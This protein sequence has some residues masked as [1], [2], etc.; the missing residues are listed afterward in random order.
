MNVKRMN[1]TPRNTCKRRAAIA[2]LF[3]LLAT[4]LET[5]AL[6]LSP[7]EVD[8]G[9]VPA[10]STYTVR[11]GLYRSPNEMDGAA[12]ITVQPRKSAAGFF[13]GETSFTIPAGQTDFNYLFSV[14]PTFASEA[15]Q[16]LYVTFL[17]TPTSISTSGV[18]VIT[19]VTQVIRFT[20][21]TAMVPGAPT[22]PSVSNGD[23]RVIVSFTAPSDNG[24]TAVTSYLVTC[25]SSLG[26][27]VSASAS[28]SPVTVTGL[29]NG[30]VYSCFVQARNVIGA[31]A[32]STTVDA[33]PYGASGGGGGASQGDRSRSTTPAPSE[34]SDDK[35]ST[36]T[37]EPTKKAPAP[38]DQPAPEGEDTGS[39]AQPSA[40]AEQE[41]SAQQGAPQGGEATSETPVQERRPGSDASP[42]AAAPSTPEQQSAPRIQSPTHPSEDAFVPS[43]DATF[44]LR[45]TGPGEN[46]PTRFLINAEPTAQAFELTQET[47]NPSVSF[48]LPDGIYY[49]HTQDAS[50][51]SAPVSTRRVMIDTTPPVVEPKVQSKPTLPFI[52]PRNEIALEVIDALAGVAQ[53]RASINGEATEVIEGRVSTRGLG[54]G[55]HSLVVDATDEAGNV[56]IQTF[57]VNVEPKFPIVR[58][59]ARV[60]SA[61]NP[62]SWFR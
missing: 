18:T 28:Q 6:G 51:A 35:D 54:W 33:R 47:S 42:E 7:P 4:P 27:T 59:I 12:L 55:T 25:T 38:S 52:A 9:Y 29:S 13:V 40:E 61:L 62:F 46:A 53:V 19:G 16:E 37:T 41:G 24:G 31:S 49:L 50:D 32:A 45:S 36:R 2:V 30:G 58:T 57:V 34:P 23:G 48:H 17:L 22:S 15:Q 43:G 8:L 14:S 20:T 3:V 39:R 60:A 1:F 11:A 5:R 56:I 21:D 44:Y 10:G 26:A